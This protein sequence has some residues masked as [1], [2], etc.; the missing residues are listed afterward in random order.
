MGVAAAWGSSR[1]ICRAVLPA[2]CI[3]VPQYFDVED[4]ALEEVVERSL[5]DACQRAI[6][7]FRAVAGA[8]AGCR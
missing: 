4:G 6:N 2:P 3:A 1:L 7:A 8:A 5:W